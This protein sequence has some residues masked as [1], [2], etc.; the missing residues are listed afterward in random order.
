MKPIVKKVFLSLFF[1]FLYE[2]ILTGKITETTLCGDIV[3]F[4][5][6]L[7]LTYLGLELFL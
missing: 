7:G 6:Y 5:L 4:T 3:A 2:I 1:I